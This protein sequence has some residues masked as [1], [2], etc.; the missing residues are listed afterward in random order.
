[1]QIQKI[2]TFREK[3]IEIDILYMFDEFFCGRPILDNLVFFFKGKSISS[4]CRISK[5]SYYLTS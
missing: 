3:S 5:V 4:K 2:I 1:M